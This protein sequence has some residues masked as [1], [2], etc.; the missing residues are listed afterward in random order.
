[1]VSITATAT[2]QASGPPP[3]VVPCMPACITRA[4]SSVHNTAPRGRPP[5]RG[6]AS[7]V[8]SGFHPTDKDPS[9]GGP[10]LNAIVLVAAP[11]AG[12]AHAGLNLVGDEQSAGRVGQLARLGKEL[13]GERPDAAF[14]L[15]GFN[16]N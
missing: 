6:L 9:V 16:E 12:A 11:L 13:L 8:I 14:A 7:V 3:K 4:T 5:A 10:G 2:A 15:D 1:M